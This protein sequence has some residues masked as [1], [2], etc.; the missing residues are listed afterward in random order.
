LDSLGGCS[1]RF[2]A[3][4]NQA[5]DGQSGVGQGRQ[6]LGQTGPLG[7]VTVF[8]SPAVFDEMEAVSRLPMVANVA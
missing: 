1:K 3:G 5:E 4:L 8:V 6:R 2:A 7:V